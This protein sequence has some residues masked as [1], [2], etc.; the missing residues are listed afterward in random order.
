MRIWE[1]NK[2]FLKVCTDQMRM[3]II[4]MMQST[5]ETTKLMEIQTFFLS[6]QDSFSPY[7][8]NTISSR[9]VMRIKKNIN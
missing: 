6:N 3:A 5:K 2:T 1:R 7:N 9:Q 8:I 4:R